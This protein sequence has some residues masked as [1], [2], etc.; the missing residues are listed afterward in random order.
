MLK[1]V[2]PHGKE[3]SLIKVCHISVRNGLVRPVWLTLDLFFVSLTL[4]SVVS[5]F[6]CATVTRTLIMY[7]VYVLK[8]EGP[9]TSIVLHA[10]G[11]TDGRSVGHS[12]LLLV[13]YNIATYKQSRGSKYLYHDLGT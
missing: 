6:I 7:E 10:Q 12:R 4:V 5:Y 2:H 9:V 13:G 8:E 3:F 1:P 11:S